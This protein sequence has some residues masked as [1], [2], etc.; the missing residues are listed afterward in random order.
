MMKKYMAFLLVALLVLSPLSALAATRPVVVGTNGMVSSIDPMAAEAAVEVLKAGGNAFDAYVAASAVLSVTLPG[1]LSAGGGGWVIMY[2]KDEDKVVSL[3][4]MGRIP[5]AATPEIFAEMESPWSENYMASLVPGNLGGWFELHKQYGSLPLEKCWERAIDYAENGFPASASYASSMRSSLLKFP[6]TAAVYFPN[7]RP[8]VEGQVVTNKDLA[9]TFKQIVEQGIE[10]LYTGDGSKMIVEHYEKNGGLITA[11]DLADFEAEWFDAVS[12]NYKGYDVFSAPPDTGN[13][14]LI[15]LQ[16]M[17][18]IEGFDVQEWGHNSAEYIHY[19]AEAFKIA[20]ADFYTHCIPEERGGTGIPTEW[21][22]SDAHIEEQRERLSTS[23]ASA[24]PGTDKYEALPAASQE[25]V[26][27]EEAGG[28]LGVIVADK[29]GNLVA[30]V[31]SAGL[32]HGTGVVV[33]GLGFTATSMIQFADRNSDYVWAIQ[34]GAKVPITIAPI[35]VMKDGN[36]WAGMGSGGTETILQGP[37]QII[38]NMVDFEMNPQEALEAPR[39]ACRGTWADP[40]GQPGKF[41]LH[42]NNQMYLEVLGDVTYKTALDLAN[43]GHY[44]YAL[45]TH[46]SSVGGYSLIVIDPDTGTLFGAGDIR[47]QNYAI[48]W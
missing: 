34:G 32:G 35:L 10:W 43:R 40:P 23:K 14:G 39:F 18:I 15:T 27:G 42:R 38:M 26:T 7:E 48:G 1:T 12:I 19:L 47:R 45:E 28:T 6:S 8:P 22:L 11:Q 24:V 41:E 37:P 44:I 20:D 25:L 30:G 5:Y 13:L 36:P 3:D 17:K 46:A 4:H 29:F 31:Q 16:A 21:L 33:E 9:N 2:A